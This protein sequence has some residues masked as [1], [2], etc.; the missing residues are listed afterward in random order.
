MRADIA[1]VGGGLAGLA[2]ARLLQQG[3][4]DFVLLEA[5]DR[6][7]G[8]ILSVGADGAPADDGFDL[9]ASWFWPA[10]QPALASLV[11]DLGLVIFAQHTDGDWLI[12]RV[13]GAPPLRY[14]AM[15]QEPPSMRIAGGTGA[16]VC[17]LARSLPPERL[18]LGTRVARLALGDAGVTLSGVDGILLLRARDVILAAP[19][20]VLAD[21]LSFDPPLDP[22]TL[23][24]WRGTATWMAPHAKLFAL[25]DRPFWRDA[26]L[27]GAAQSTLGPMTEIHDATGASGAA[28]LFG[29]LG[30]GADHRRAIGEAAV[31]EAC[32]AQFGRLFGPPAARP[33]ATLFKDWAA[34][35][36]IAT[37]ADRIATGHR[38]PGPL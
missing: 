5:R 28:A 36:L 17:A 1:V 22:A 8:R 18:R 15:R 26:G 33:I 23:A 31:I 32:V 11:H 4:T 9:G 27:S 2:A 19:P 34:D 6:L 14:P 35:S 16:L 25:Y 7:G 30:I 37:P 20:R 29:F 12:E 38:V 3:G 13:R 10:M 24:R 21:A